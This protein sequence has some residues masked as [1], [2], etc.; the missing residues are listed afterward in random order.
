M[1][2]F[3]DP[4]AYAQALITLLK[5]PAL[6]EQLGMNAYF[7]T[8]NMA[9]ENVALE[10]LKLFS[11]HSDAIALESEHKRFPRVNLSHLFRMTDNF[12]IIQFA[13]LSLPDIS[14]GYTLD[15]NAR[16]LIVAC[17]CHGKYKPKE[18]LCK[19]IEVYLSFIEFVMGKDGRFCNYVRPDR[20]VD[21]VF[22]EK[23][24]LDDANGRA[25]WALAVCVVTDTL[26]Q[27]ILDKARALLK[28]KLEHY[29]M[30][31]SPRSVA[32]HVKGFCLI[33]EKMREFEGP[34]LAQL[35]ISHCDRLVSLY[36]AVSSPQWQ[37]FE[38]YLTSSNAVLSEALILGY[39]HTRNS[40]Y[41]D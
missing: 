4:H 15:D 32:F 36:R 22:N 16:A 21:T 27:Q 33:L 37:W 23:E 35:I 6:R 29:R 31:E 11:K 8:R 18:E 14:S 12:G 41:F 39:K 26:P 2:D 28:K 24:N 5:D 3:R 19:R 17:L 7:R 40:E 10:Y 38:N 13:K 1:V 20:K 9:W 25:F 34:D 30:F